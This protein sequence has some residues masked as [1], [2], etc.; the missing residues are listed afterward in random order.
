MRPFELPEAHRLRNASGVRWKQMEAFRH[1]KLFP[2]MVQLSGTFTPNGLRNA[3]APMYL[4]DGGKRLGPTEDG[5]LRKYFSEPTHEY[6][7]WQP[8]L[9]VTVDDQWNYTWGQR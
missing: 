4:L 3:W 2:R 9:G 5:Y 6:G 1:A 7:K 8:K